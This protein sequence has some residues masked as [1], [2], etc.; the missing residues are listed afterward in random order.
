MERRHFTPTV[1]AG[2]RL[3][4]LATGVCLVA[5]VAGS[6]LLCSGTGFDPNPP[7]ADQVAD[8]LR[9]DIPVGTPVAEAARRLRR[10]GFDVS[11]ETDAPWAGREGRMNYLYGDRQKAVSFFSAMCWQVAVVHRDGVVTEVLVTAGDVSW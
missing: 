2:R 5:V 11:S 8:R 9:A 1:S 3:F 10:H 6:V 7:S 4:K